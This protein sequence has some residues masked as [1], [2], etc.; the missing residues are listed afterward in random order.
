MNKDKIKW[1]LTRKRFQR[2]K[3]KKKMNQEKLNLKRKWK[4]KEE[5]KE[6]FEHK[7]RRD[8]NL[9]ENNSIIKCLEENKEEK[10][11]NS[12]TLKRR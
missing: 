9:N 1:N 3:D 6:M 10:I 12:K 7:L 2:C 8:K 5:I 11:R 4:I